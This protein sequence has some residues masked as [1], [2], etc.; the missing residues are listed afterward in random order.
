MDVSKKFNV[1]PD[2]NIAGVLTL[3]VENWPEQRERVGLNAVRYIC[4]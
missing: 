3:L 2:G 4:N 1:V